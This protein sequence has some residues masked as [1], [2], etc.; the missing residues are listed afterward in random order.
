MCNCKN[1]QWFQDAKKFL[2]TAN[3]YD[4]RYYT[5]KFL[6][7]NNYCGNN[8]TSI[9]GILDYLKSKEINLDREK[10]QQTVL[11]ELK[12]LGIVAT[13]VYPR[14]SGSVFIPCSEDNV[15][16][17]AK[18]ILERVKSELENIQS[19]AKHTSFKELFDQLIQQVDSAKNQL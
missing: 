10:F 13:L 7:D 17:S 6:I 2:T 3:N 5:I 16:E 19:I 14:G 9:E 12:R 18:M 11:G 4:P 1:S 8:G 15:K